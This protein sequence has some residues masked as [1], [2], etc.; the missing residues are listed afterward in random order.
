MQKSVESGD[1]EDQKS[2]RCEQE[3]RNL[4]AGKSAK[5]SQDTLPLSRVADLHLRQKKL[6]RATKK[7]ERGYAELT[8]LL[9]KYDLLG[10]DFTANALHSTV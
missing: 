8:E 6:L 4:S 2:M 10:W 9:Q 1:E 5:H 3:Q 7:S